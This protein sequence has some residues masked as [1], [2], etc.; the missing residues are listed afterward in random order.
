M[1]YDVKKANC[2]LL[3]RF[4]AQLMDDTWVKGPDLVR[5]FKDYGLSIYPHD[6]FGNYIQYK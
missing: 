2:T 6:V 3:G 5:I 4:S 1:I